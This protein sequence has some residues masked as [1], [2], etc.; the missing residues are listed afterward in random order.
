VASV[1]RP[2]RQLVG[3]TRV[4][5]ETGQTAT[6]R[7]DVDADLTG[8]TGRDLR[9]RVE[10]GRVVLTV[11]QSAA[12]PGLSAEVLLQGAV[13]FLDHTRAMTTPVSVVRL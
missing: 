8:F 12:D 5:L 4:A 11:A 10:P 7:F 6:V 1:T 3:F 13:R 2:V 9:R